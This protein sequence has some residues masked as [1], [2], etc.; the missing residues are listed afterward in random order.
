MR[1]RGDCGV[2]APRIDRKRSS[3]KRGLI[4]T[5]EYDVGVGDGGV[6]AVAVARRSGIGARRDRADAQRARFIDPRDGAAARADLR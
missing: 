1:E 4:Q 5:S 2:R 3:D 6:V